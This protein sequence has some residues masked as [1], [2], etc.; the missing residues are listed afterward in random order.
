MMSM[1]SDWNSKVEFKATLS[2]EAE[3]TVKRQVGAGDYSVLKKGNVTLTAN[4]ARTETVTITGNDAESNYIAEVVF[5]VDG[6]GEE[7]TYT[8]EAWNVIV[9]K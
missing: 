4:T 7:I 8:S 1:K 3:Y 5:T 6:T 2:G 9:A